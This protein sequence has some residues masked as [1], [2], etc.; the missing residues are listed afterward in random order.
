MVVTTLYRKKT[1]NIDWFRIVCVV[2]FLFVSLNSIASDNIFLQE[3][4]DSHGIF[5]DIKLGWRSY[6]YEV[7]GDQ[8]F[9]ANFPSL[10]VGL[11]GILKNGFFGHGYYEFSLGDGDGVVESAWN[12]E[13]NSNRNLGPAVNFKRTDWAVLSGFLIPH[14]WKDD[15]D[16]GIFAGYKSGNS[17]ADFVPYLNTQQQ[18]IDFKYDLVS[19]GPFV[20]VGTGIR[21]GN[22][23]IFG[24]RIAYAWLNTDV[25]RKTNFSGITDTTV[26]NG[27][28]SGISVG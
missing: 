10:R 15:V 4:L 26:F 9:D 17:K 1:K 7:D 11:F 27:N 14:K 19:A 24:V 20:G 28:G 21:V 25:T 5:P 8:V 3:R 18:T 6:N 16:L 13:D 23:G 2:P 12:G 22:F